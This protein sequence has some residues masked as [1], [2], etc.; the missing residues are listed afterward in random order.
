MSRFT[1]WKA[2]APVVLAL[3]ALL[4]A[5]TALAAAPDTGD[6]YSITLPGISAAP[7]SHSIQNEASFGLIENEYDFFFMPWELADIQFDRTRYL[8][9]HHADETGALGTLLWT[10]LSNNGSVGSNYGGVEG[11]DA[12]SAGFLSNLWGGR[13]G[14]NLGYLN[15]KYQPTTVYHD[16]Q[17][18][19]PTSTA[20]STGS[21]DQLDAY[22]LYLTYGRAAGKA[23]QW[24]VGLTLR[25]ATGKQN[26]FDQTLDSS[27]NTIPY[28]AYSEKDTASNIVLV[29]GVKFKPKQD[30]SFSVFAE[31]GIPE[32]KRDAAYRERFPLTYAELTGDAI[33]PYRVSENTRDKLDGTT[34]KIGGRFNLYKEDTDW[35]FD[36][37]YSNESLEYKP[38]FGDRGSSSVAGDPPVL[39]WSHL[40][41]AN[42]FINEWNLTKKDVKN[43]AL[44]LDAHM[45]HRLGQADLYAGLSISTMSSKIDFEDAGRIQWQPW[46]SPP[47]S[48]PAVAALA[49]RSYYKWET[50]SYSPYVATRIP[51]NNWLA[52]IGG[53][54]WTHTDEKVTDDPSHY[55][56][57]NS[58]FEIWNDGSYSWQTYVTKSSWSNATTRLGAQILFKQVALDIMW[59]HGGYGSGRQTVD[60]S[61]L[62]YGATFK[63]GRS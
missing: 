22:D 14:V 2:A 29:G 34:Y 37:A 60:N 3:V 41:S 56:Q 51:I 7:A 42:N 31:V 25:N 18:T 5:G 62:I 15:G 36:L 57:I 45:A 4:S 30:L 48:D 55:T 39:T 33:Y 46:S 49:A 52:I 20:Y 28:D 27:G 58:G 35:Q 43:D 47:Y 16:I 40:D 9:N 24:G 6:A 13:F 50:T 54:G 1:S 26:P 32:Y 12:F 23:M 53:A 61:R 8:G 38:F 44:M 63:L 19:A 11:Q 21:S 17:T 59:E 10:Q